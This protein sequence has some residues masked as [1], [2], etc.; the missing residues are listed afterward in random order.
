MLK[1]LN[2]RARKFAGFLSRLDDL[3]LVILILMIPV[4]VFGGVIIR[5][6][7]FLKSMLWSAELA[8]LF[9]VWLVFWGAAHADRLGLHYRADV[10]QDLLGRRAQLTL[11]CFLKVILLPTFGLLI[12][13][14]LNFCIDSR[15][16]VTHMLGWPTII[17]SLPVL[18]CSLLI[19]IYLTIDF[20]KKLRELL[21]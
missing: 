12:W 11:Q 1:N 17:R 2:E 4:V 15:G 18:L 9:L 3:P 13:A 10:L 14:A 16:V 8:R 20:T 6:L 5:Y 19:F 21:R 7:P